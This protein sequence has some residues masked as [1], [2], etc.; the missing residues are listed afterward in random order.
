MRL[1]FLT[2]ALS[3]GLAAGALAVLAVW[4]LTVLVGSP[5][6]WALAPW[7]VS[8]AALGFGSATY[9]GERIAYRRSLARMRAVGEP[10]AYREE[11]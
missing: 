9:F 11:G 8:F 1:A 2:G 7:L 3:A 6:P 5:G 4:V 10:W